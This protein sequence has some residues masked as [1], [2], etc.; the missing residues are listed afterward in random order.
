MNWLLERLGLMRISD[1]NAQLREG[2]L[3]LEQQIDQ[4]DAHIIWLKSCDL[5]C[6][7]K[8]DMKPQIDNCIHK[9]TDDGTCGNQKNTT[10]ECH[11]W[12]CPELRITGKE[13]NH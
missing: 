5:V 2:T 7:C 9:D 13:V 3:A 6:D 10:P 8:N 12:C 1:H 11:Q 4:M